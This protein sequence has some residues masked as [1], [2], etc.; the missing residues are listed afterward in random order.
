MALVASTAASADPE[1]GAIIDPVASESTGGDGA[2]AADPRRRREE[3]NRMLGRPRA[4]AAHRPRNR[5]WYIS[6]GILAL[7]VVISAAVRSNQKT[8]RKVA[9]EKARHRPGPRNPWLNEVAV[10]LADL[11]L[12]EVARNT[13]AQLGGVPIDG[14]IG[15]EADRLRVYVTLFSDQRRA[16]QAELGLK[17]KPEVRDAMANGATAIK[18]AG[19]VVFVANGRGGVVDE[20]HLDEVV[21]MVGRVAVTATVGRRYCAAGRSG[22]CC[23]P[24][25]APVASSPDPDALE[26]PRK[27][28]ELRDAGV[29]E[30][31]AKKAE[32]LGR[33]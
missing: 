10:A 3:A 4:H 27:L 21:R 7:L 17:A 30:F 14:D 18:T 6:L 19:R 32:L 28:G 9:E 24:R 23:A 20:F 11:G 5:V 13:G 29:L 31:E 16:R 33:I 1:S 8:E 15:L 2:A 12:K 25:S 22:P 26:Q